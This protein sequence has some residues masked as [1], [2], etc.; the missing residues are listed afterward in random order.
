MD[1][2]LG[3]KTFAFEKDIAQ[4]EVHLNQSQ[5]DCP[6]LSS[7]KTLETEDSAYFFCQP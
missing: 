6:R 5:D 2:I 7:V 3:Y 1:L 4:N